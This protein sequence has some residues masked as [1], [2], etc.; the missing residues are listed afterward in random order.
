MLC[1]FERQVAKQKVIFVSGMQLRSI[2]FESVFW[3]RFIQ[4][5]VESLSLLQE[6]TAIF[7]TG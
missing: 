4:I 6:T 3:W 2:P 1:Y 7:S 5:H